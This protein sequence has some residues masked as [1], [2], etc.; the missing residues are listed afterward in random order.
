LVFLG[1]RHPNPLVPAHEMAQKAQNLAAEIGEK[2]LSII[3]IEWVSYQERETLLSEADIGVALHPIHVETR[4]SI[5]TR[6]LDY[7]WARL[8]ILVT[9]GDITSEWVR[10]YNL[11]VVVPP[12]DPQ[13][14]ATGLNRL[15]DGQKE[16]FS[17]AF[18]PLF[19]R[20]RWSRVVE[21][22]KRYCLEGGYAPDRQERSVQ[23]EPEPTERSNFARAIYIFRTEGPKALLHRA[24]RHLQWRLSRP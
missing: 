19:K 18:E 15:L 3:F 20:Y 12:F 5:R 16:D 22:L 13:A 6:M 4:Y 2:D 14:V 7:L 8:P 23:P 21:P 17:P 1:T 24:W 9:D 10:Q 11:G